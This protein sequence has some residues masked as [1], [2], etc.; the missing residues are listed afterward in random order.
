MIDRKTM[1]G[2]ILQLLQEDPSRYVSFGPYW[3]LVK[4][5]LKRFYG[6]E[7]LSLLGEHM[8]REAAAHMPEHETIDEALSA[9][10]DFHR[11]HMAYGMGESTFVDPETGDEWILRDPDG[12]GG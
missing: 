3:P 5:L 6:Q 9:A 2:S 10:I 8:D 11:N 12:G 1:A 4:S 7:N